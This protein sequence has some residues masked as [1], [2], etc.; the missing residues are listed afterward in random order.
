V[1]VFIALISR[2]G[3]LQVAQGKFYEQLADET[4]SG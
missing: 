1:L 4:V 3:Y 2:L